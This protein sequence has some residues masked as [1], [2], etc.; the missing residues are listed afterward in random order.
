MFN[1]HDGQQLFTEVSIYL[2][3]CGHHTW[4]QAIAILTILEWSETIINFSSHPCCVDSKLYHEE[5]ATQL[6]EENQN[7]SLT[8]ELRADTVAL[9][10]IRRSL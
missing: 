9:R 2:S 5:L 7:N 4:M 1:A 8:T 10:G 3:I 6:P